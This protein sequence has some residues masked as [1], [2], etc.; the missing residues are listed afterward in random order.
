MPRQSTVYNI[1]IASPSDCTD[2]RE[3]IKSAIEC[4]NIAHSK[5]QGAVLLAAS[6]D[7]HTPPLQGNRPQAIITERVLADCDVL[8]ALFWTRLGQPTGVAPSGTAEEIQEHLAKG[9]KVLIYICSKDIPK[10]HDVGQLQSLKEFCSGLLNSGIVQHFNTAEE[11]R[12]NFSTHLA[13]VMNDLLSER[14]NTMASLLDN[15]HRTEL[16]EDA[17]ALL[18]AAADSQSGQVM[19]LRHMDGLHIEG[20]NKTFFRG[21]TAREET[22]WLELVEAIRRD[23]L[24]RSIGGNGAICQVTSKG[25]KLAD[26]LRKSVASSL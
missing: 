24:I 11:L 16:D 1:M 7:T 9:K 5:H 25:Y 3:E 12:S 14:S 6:G 8:V 21:G 13:Q 10:D 17:Q 22:H 26:Q 18:V 20:G 23:E 19:A 15:D 2:Y 4:W